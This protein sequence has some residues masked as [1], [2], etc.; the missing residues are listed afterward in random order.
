MKRREVRK[1]WPCHD[2]DKKKDAWEHLHQSENE[3]LS[4]MDIYGAC[5]SSFKGA[6]NITDDSDDESYVFLQEKICIDYV[7]SVHHQM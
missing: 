5:S 4:L 7:C 1:R 3:K 2:G 6:R